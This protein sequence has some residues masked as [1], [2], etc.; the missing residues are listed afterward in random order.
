MTNQISQ[1]G[2]CLDE[3]P[4]NRRRFIARTVTA[5]ALA[6]ASLAAASTALAAPAE[7]PVGLPGGNTGSRRMRISILSYSFRGLLEA[8]MMDVFGYLETCK[9]RYGL[10]AADIWNGFFP[11]VEEGFLKKVRAALDEREMTLADLCVDKAHI[12]EDDASV[13][14]ANYANAKAHLRAAEILGARFMRV[15]AGGRDKTW[16]EEQFDHIVKRYREYAQWA[17]DH[18]FKV[19]AE[20]HWGTEGIW[21][22]LQKLYRAVDH[23]G[24]GLSI[25]L[26]GWQGTAE[27]K[28]E[29]DRLVAPWACHTHIAWNITEGPL[30]EKLTQLKNAGY[31]GYYSVEHHTAKN[32][33]TEIAIQLAKV[34]DVLDRWRT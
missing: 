3:N 26:D 25:H 23:R 16:S 24:F 4:T 13:R 1:T 34:R 31:P 7:T 6:A 21:A 14:E 8:G 32:E 11:S 12:W 30:V 9:Y 10:D 28:A 18:G 17:W 2:R 29:A 20:N 33:Y 15:D 5:G 22:N 27:E 19:G